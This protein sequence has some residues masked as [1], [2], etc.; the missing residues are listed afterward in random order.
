MFLQILFYVSVLSFLSFSIIKAV[1]YATMPIHLRWELYPLAH[2]VKRPWGGSYYEELDWWK[3]PRK[4]NL[5]GE[6]KTI[7]KELLFFTMYYR[8][9]RKYWFA[10]FPFHIGIFSFM[11]WLLCLIVGALM[12]LAGITLSTSSGNVLGLGVYYLTLLCG[13]IAFIAGTIGC[14]G[15]IVR[16]AV[17]KELSMYTAPL[18]YFNLSFLLATFLSGL[19]AWIWFD[20]SFT[21]IRDFMKSLFNFTSLTHMNPAT[22]TNIVF[23]CLFLIYMPHTSMMHYIGKYFTYHKVLWDEEPNIKGSRVEKKIEAQLN[24]RVSWSAPHIQAGKKW[25][26]LTTGRGSEVEEEVK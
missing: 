15:L 11:S 14:F 16:R 8:Q 9:R 3:K 12:E 13:V 18:G 25:I 24:N 19:F 21:T 1:K 4:K 23:I 7:G 17:D 10:V 5:L 22:Y 2:E 20:P 26:E 6:L